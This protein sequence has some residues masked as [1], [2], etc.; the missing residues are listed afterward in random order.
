MFV[1]YGQASYD[2]KNLSERLVYLPVG[3]FAL[4]WCVAEGQSAYLGNCWAET[5]TT[6]MEH[7]ECLVTS[8]YYLLRWK[9][10]SKT[11]CD[12]SSEYDRFKDIL[13]ENIKYKDHVKLPNLNHHSSNKSYALLW[14]VW[15]WICLE[16]FEN[17][18]SLNCL[19]MNIP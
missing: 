11:K 5:T 9:D 13:K 12:I 17:E 8:I 10:I 16:W 3:D 19:K 1:I 7:D 4:S 15:K 18:Y 2:K 6:F 14:I